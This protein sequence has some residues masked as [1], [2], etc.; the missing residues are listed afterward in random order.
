MSLSINSLIIANANVQGVSLRPVVG[1]Y[2][3]VF[4]LHLTVHPEREFARCA[5]IIGARITVKAGGSQNHAIGFAR[6]E[7][8]FE[9]R[10]RPRQS[11]MT[12]G[13]VLPM[14][15]HQ[16]AALEDQR[17]S[18][19]LDF[20]LEATGIG[21]DRNGEEQVQDTWR[22]HVPRSDWIKKL[23]DAKARNMLLLQIPLPFPTRSKKWGQVA[24]ELGRAEEHFRNGDYHACAASCRTVLQEVGFQKYK[25]RHWAGT[26]LNRLADGRDGM[27][28]DERE[29]A[30]WGAVRHYTHQAHHSG[31]EGGVT[32]Y[33]RAEAQFVLT[34]TASF[35]ARMQAG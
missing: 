25:K 32:V 8:A 33:S 11:T 4:G 28:K 18:G 15:P 6:P 30:L 9:I 14:Q 7:G 5:S 1:A 22:V 27:T 24:S 31:S 10:Q 20:E 3:L 29:A 12:P 17:G 26:L 35:V 19:D 23:R 34:L 21:T 2:E 13:L 16:L